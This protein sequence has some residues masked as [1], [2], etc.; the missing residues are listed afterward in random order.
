MLLLYPLQSRFYRI[1][2]FTLFIIVYFLFFKNYFF[3]HG[4]KNPNFDGL[5]VKFAGLYF[6]RTRR[7]CKIFFVL[8]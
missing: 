6:K 1:L 2:L 4:K 5:G 3:K 8:C 7:L